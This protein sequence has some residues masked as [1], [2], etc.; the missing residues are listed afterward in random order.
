MAISH[1]IFQPNRYGLSLQPIDNKPVFTVVDIGSQIGDI[2]L[3]NLGERGFYGKQQFDPKTTDHGLIPDS[4]F[5]AQD[6]EWVIG[7][8]VDSDQEG[9]QLL[10]VDASLAI[11]A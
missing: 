3:L 5:F 1:L 7:I 4:V 2:Y 10:N 8:G 6:I 9:Y 11:V